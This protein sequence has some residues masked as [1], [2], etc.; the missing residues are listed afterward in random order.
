[1]NKL[2]YRLATEDDYN[3]VL[4]LMRQLNPDDPQIAESLGRETLKTIVKTDGLSIH[5]AEI[6]SKPVATCYLNVVPNLTRAG[7]PYALVENVVTDFKYRRRGIARMLLKQ[8]VAIAFHSGCYKIMLLTGC[9]TEIHTFYEKCG[10]DKMSKT[11]FI[12]RAQ[13]SG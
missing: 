13:T 2:T 8:V 4:A 3:V 7:R 12:I 9:D 6:D 11:A 5:L 1:M 10:F